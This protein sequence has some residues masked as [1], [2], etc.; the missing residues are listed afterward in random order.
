MV[1]ATEAPSVPTGRCS[2]PRPPRPGDRLPEV[3]ARPQPDDSSEGSSVVPA[4]YQSRVGPIRA[5]PVYLSRLYQ[6][7][8]DQPTLPPR[9]P[10][11]DSQTAQPSG[12]QSKTTA[13]A[14]NT[15]KNIEEDKTP[16]SHF[17]MLTFLVYRVSDRSFGIRSQKKTG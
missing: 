4:D 9:N 3:P 13:N 17:P 11:V 16:V 8:R 15:T 7:Y 14:E 2:S 6:P 1:Q 12:G 5:T 10:S